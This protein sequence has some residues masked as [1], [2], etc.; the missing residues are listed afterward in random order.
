MDITEVFRMFMS[1]VAIVNRQFSQKIRIFQ[2]DNGSEF[3]CLSNY[4]LAT[5]IVFQSTC[6]GILQ[7]NGWVKR[8][9]KHI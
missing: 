3:F 1:F 5:R 7:Q 6:V 9:H 2:S 4:F 8:K